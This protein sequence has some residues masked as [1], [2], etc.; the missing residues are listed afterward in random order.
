MRVEALKEELTRLYPGVNI[1]ETTITDDAVTEIVGEIDRTL[2]NSE[3]DVAVVVADRSGEHYHKIITEEYEVIKGALKVY[4]NGELTELQA[5]ETVVIEPGTK[6]WVEGDA[7]W[8][9]CYSTPDWFP[10]DF[11]PVE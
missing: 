9:Y 8:F 4:K 10:G 6:H 11:Y 7:T 1:K 3:R 5:G 2:V